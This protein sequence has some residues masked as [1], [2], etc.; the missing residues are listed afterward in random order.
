MFSSEIK[1]SVS[2]RALA[3][4]NTVK[5]FDGRMVTVTSDGLMMIDSSSYTVIYDDINPSL[6]TLTTGYQRDYTDHKTKHW[7]NWYDLER[8]SRHLSPH[9]DVCTFPDKHA[10]FTYG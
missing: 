2:I 3:T 9:H 4:N 8:I 7:S 5:R 10:E 6:F 1:P